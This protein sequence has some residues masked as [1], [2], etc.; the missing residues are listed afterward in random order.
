MSDDMRD[1]YKFYGVYTNDWLTTWGGDTFNHH[2]VK[3]WI[4]EYCSTVTYTAWSAAGAKFIYPHNIKKKYYLEGVVEGE[5]TFGNYVKSY[6]SDYRV[7]IIKINTDTTETVLATTGVINV[8][9]MITKDDAIVYHFWIDCFNAKEISEYDRIGVFIEWDIIGHSS[10][11][12][13]LL[14]G[15]RETGYAYDDV[16]VDIPFIL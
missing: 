8:N 3:D 12:A 1:Y 11:T 15:N 13:R 16:W 6:V 2:L 14:N 4:S 7:N 5:I 9:D 10:V